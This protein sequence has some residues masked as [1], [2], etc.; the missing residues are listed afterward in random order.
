MKGNKITEE[1][2]EETLKTK[3]TLTEE[4]QNI[5]EYHFIEN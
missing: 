4:Q 5:L 3:G 1:I 2:K